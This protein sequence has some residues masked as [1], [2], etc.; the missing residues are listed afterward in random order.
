MLCRKAFFICAVPRSGSS[1]LCNLLQMTGVAGNPMEYGGEEDERT[2]RHGHGFSDHRNYFLHFA[3]RLSVTSNG[4]FSAKLMFEHMMSFARD[5]KRYKGIDAGSPLATIDLAFGA[6]RYV[7]MLRK[8]KERQAISFF[9][10]AQSGSWTWAQRADKPAC[11]DMAL[12]ERAAQFL[13]EKEA[14]WDE[15][16]CGVDPFRRTTV[17]YEDFADDREHTLSRLLAWL[18][19]SEHVPPLNAPSMKKQSDAI[20]EQWLDAW[21]RDRKLNMPRENGT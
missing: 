12:L 21:Q 20:S 7:Q 11:Y 2:W 17:Y 3:H 1:L 4:V 19:I 16:L 5:V 10:A 8:D 15:F 9:R 18:Q 14:A 13:R 6:P